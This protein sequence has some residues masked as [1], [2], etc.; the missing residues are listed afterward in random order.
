MSSSVQYSALARLLNHNN[1][2][3]DLEE[4]MRHSLVPV[5]YPAQMDVQ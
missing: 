5:G 4:I 3:H 1:R 2:A